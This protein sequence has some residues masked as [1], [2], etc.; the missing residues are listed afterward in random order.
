MNRHQRRAKSSSRGNSDRPRLGTGGP[1]SVS[2]QVNFG[3]MLYEQGKFNEAVLAYRD[4][5]RVNPGSA[6]A[7]SN[8]GNALRA[9]GKLSEAMKA[10]R[11]AI[12]INPAF[13]EAYSNLGVCFREQFKPHDAVAAYRK[14]I[15]LKPTVAET[16]DN[17]GLVLTELGSFSEARA[18]FVEAIRLAPGKAKFLYDLGDIVRFSPGDPHLLAMERLASNSSSLSIKD[19]TEL[20]FALGKAYDDAGQHPAAFR[21]WLEGN[22]L[23]RRQIAY[24]ETT[25]LGELDRAQ[26]VF[27]S[28]FIQRRANGGDPSSAPI[29][30]FGM[31]R[32]GTT[33][34]EQIVSSHPKVVGGGELEYFRESVQELRMATSPELCLGMAGKD[35]RDLGTRYLNKIKRHA[36]SENHITDKMPMNFIFAGLIHL[37]LPNASIIHVTRD[38]IDTCISC[39]S[40]LFVVYRTSRTTWLNSAGTTDIIKH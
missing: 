38:P 13:A 24:D 10:Y 14:A 12:R 30:I 28:E 16:H 20:H 4:A 17:L 40:R 1:L 5:I 34:I 8:L 19:R 22:A 29:F 23:K 35:F 3:I 32:S 37:A 7:H 2:A 36:P 15:A 33:L 25:T 27:T 6:E 31:P 39:F 26:T 11:K 9:Q 21:Q 18:A